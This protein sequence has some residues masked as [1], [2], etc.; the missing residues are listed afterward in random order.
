MAG[1]TQH[2][3]RLVTIVAVALS[4]SACEGNTRGGAGTTTST[5]R[6]M[7]PGLPPHGYGPD[8]LAP[9][10]DPT[11]AVVLTAIAESFLTPHPP[12]LPRPKSFS[13][14]TA[15]PP[16]M[17]PR[18]PTSTPDPTGEALLEQMLQGRPLREWPTGVP[19]YTSAPPSLTITAIPTAVDTPSP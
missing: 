10:A 4:V 15:N 8:P 17:G 19:F 7:T 12:I 5:P 13:T 2:P 6:T 16:F 14:P 3:F 1:Y 11:M 9:T 18:L